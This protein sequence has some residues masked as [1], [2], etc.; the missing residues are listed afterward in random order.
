MEKKYNVDMLKMSLTQEGKNLADKLGAATAT[1]AAAE[2]ALGKAGGEL[3]ETEKSKA[4]DEQRLA[5]TKMACET[6]ANEWAERQK[7]AAGE[8]GAIAKAKEILS[9]GVKAFVQVSSKTQ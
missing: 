4:A 2:E 1:K 3:A 8:M 5:E 9:T 6:K 7:E